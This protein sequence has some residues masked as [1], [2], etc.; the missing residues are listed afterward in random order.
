VDFNPEVFRDLKTR[1]VNV[2]YGDI[3]NI[4]TLHHAGIDEAKL[5]ISTI[6]DDILVGIDNFKLIGQ[7]RN[8]CPQARIVVTAGSP[9]Q[10]LKLYKAGADYV[11]RPNF[12]AARHLLEILDLLLRR[13]V[14]DLV[15]KEIEQLSRQRE[16]LA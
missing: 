2:V 5:V 6:T 8:L 14:T 9:T 15:E 1:G 3:S 10:A 7:I 13:E 11:L 12:L 4:P 16:V